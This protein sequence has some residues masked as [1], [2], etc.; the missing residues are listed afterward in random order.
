MER[1][2]HKKQFPC[3]KFPAQI[4]PSLILTYSRPRSRCGRC[5]DLEIVRQA[6]VERRALT[7]N[8]GMSSLRSPTILAGSVLSAVEDLVCTWELACQ[9]RIRE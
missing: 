5:V 8:P 4:C 9:D 1:K 3:F 2:K 6:C 7:L